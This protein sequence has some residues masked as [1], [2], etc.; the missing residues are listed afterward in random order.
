MQA[1]PFFIWQPGEGAPAR[2]RFGRDATFVRYGRLTRI[3]AMIKPRAQR[4]SEGGEASVKYDC[5]TG[6][7][8]DP[9]EPTGVLGVDLGVVNIATDSEGRNYSGAAL[10]AYRERI[11]RLRS[12]LQSKGTRSAKRHL[13]AIRK[14]QSRHTRDVN[15]CISKQIVKTAVAEQK[16][17]AFEELEGIGKRANGLGKQMRKLIKIHI[18]SCGWMV[19]NRGATVL[20]KAKG[21]PMDIKYKDIQ[22]I[23]DL[24]NYVME[25][26]EEYDWDMGVFET[27]ARLRVKTH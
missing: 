26:L 6:R 4:I 18:D 8:G 12:R 17:L 25:A 11:Q 22:G 20:G 3:C 9:F 1:K 27:A 16:A 14:Q 2:H 19:Y 24:V 13:R 5:G 15:H 10:R 21:E 7:E 23:R